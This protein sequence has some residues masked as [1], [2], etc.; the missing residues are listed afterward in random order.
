MKDT[1]YTA[2]GPINYVRGSKEE[3]SKKKS[4]EIDAFSFERE[5]EEYNIIWFVFFVH[6]HMCRQA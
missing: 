5:I 3:I 1:W 4:E 6:I 2:G